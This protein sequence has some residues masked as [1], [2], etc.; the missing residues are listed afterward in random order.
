MSS[1][2]DKNSNLLEVVFDAFW[3]AGCSVFDLIFGREKAFDIE[4]FYEVCELKNPQGEYP[5]LYRKF[6]VDNGFR[7]LMTIPIGL[8]L[9]D[10]VKL[11]EALEQQIKTKVVIIYKNGFVEITS[12]QEDLKEL[13]SFELQ[14][15]SQIS[16]GIK[17]PLGYSLDGL[18]YISLKEHPHSFVVGSTGGGKSV[19]LKSIMVFLIN[20][21]ST[22]ELEIYLGDLKFVEFALFKNV[23]L[24]K[25][26]KTS[27]L[28][29]TEQVRTLLE[30][31]ERR[32]Q[33]FESVGVT[34]IFDY[35]KKFPKRKLKYQILIIEEVVNLLQ[36]SKKTAM[37]LLKRLISI[38]RNSG[39]Y[40]IFSTQR[41]S[42]DVIDSV[43]KAN[44]SNRIVFHTESEKDS[45]ICLD[46]IGAEA[47]DIKGRGILKVGS[48]KKVFQGFY[49]SDDE[50]KEYIKPYLVNRKFVE[51]V[52][53]VNKGDSI[54]DKYKDFKPGFVENKENGEGVNKGKLE[55]AENL[56]DLSFL[57]NI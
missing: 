27:V 15:A 35:N 14:E 18:E 38:S 51:P 11:Q 47:L 46:E 37:K 9:K 36:D 55:D 20:N 48:Q 24:V 26:F 19:C 1:N 12:I 52:V 40:C 10:F 6:K 53:E 54:F 56:Q 7:F 23:G 2:K 22:E 5:K 21:Y 45:V 57:D 44:I 31:T 8:S 41:P 42:A 25:D 28:D 4:N 32:Y 17:I 3:D 34:N 39:L 43:V 29:V 50:V 30:E 13:Y 49:I 33:L 16:E